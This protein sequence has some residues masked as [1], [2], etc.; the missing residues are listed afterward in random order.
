V[1]KA[2]LL[3]SSDGNSTLV[4]DDS[5]EKLRAVCIAAFGALKG[6]AKDQ[7]GQTRFVEGPQLDQW[8]NI[9]ADRILSLVGQETLE[10]FWSI[11]L[12]RGPVPGLAKGPE[13]VQ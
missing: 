1:A 11:K 12:A 6:V 10:G 3:Y 8:R 5:E 13:G 2:P 7:Q 9:V 4:A